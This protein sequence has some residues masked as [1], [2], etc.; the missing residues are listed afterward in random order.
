MALGPKEQFVPLWKTM[1]D[2]ARLT[3]G[4]ECDVQPTHSVPRRKVGRVISPSTV[5]QEDFMDQQ[6]AYEMLCNS[7]FTTS[8]IERLE[9]LRKD[10]AEKEHY[11]PSA[12]QRRL[13]FARWLV[14]TGR[15]T[16]Q[17]A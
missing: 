9:R 4:A 2:K 15:L 17:I 7:G 3:G 8:E 10:Y 6:E 1:L 11:Q 13:E 14:T 12:D 16:E 5:L